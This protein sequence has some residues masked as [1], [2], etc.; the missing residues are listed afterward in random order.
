MGCLL[1]LL[2]LLL[3]LFPDRTGPNKR[4]NDTL[5][6]LM[7]YGVKKYRLMSTQRN[8]ASC[9]HKEISL[10][11]PQSL[12][13]NALNNVHTQ[14]HDHTLLRPAYF[15]FTWHTEWQQHMWRHK[16][17]CGSAS[18]RLGTAVMNKK[19]AKLRDLNYSQSSVH[20]FLKRIK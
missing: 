16:N 3:L 2:L 14:L 8:I 19:T 13:N 4:I 20:F 12:R 18:C 9:P 15:V 5:Y 17:M 11:C 1:L 10:I 7:K 6:L